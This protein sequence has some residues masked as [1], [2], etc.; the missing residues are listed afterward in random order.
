MVNI[1]R[2]DD[3]FLQTMVT[4]E[5]AGKRMCLSEDL[6]RRKHKGEK[7]KIWQRWLSGRGRQEKT[8]RVPDTAPS[9]NQD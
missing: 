5:A 8:T 3:H 9:P 4:L 2:D 7:I 1:E 6:G